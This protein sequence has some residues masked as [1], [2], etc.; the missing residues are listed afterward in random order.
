MDD[1]SQQDYIDFLENEFAKS[2]DCIGAMQNFS[3]SLLELLDFLGEN[4]GED[5][6]PIQIKSQAYRDIFEKHLEACTQAI[7]EFKEKH[8]QL[9]DPED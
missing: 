3:L 7:E 9:I 8:G 6:E 4:Y 1:F 2:L 5:D